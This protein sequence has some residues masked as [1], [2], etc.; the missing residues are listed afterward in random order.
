LVLSIIFS[1]VPKKVALDYISLGAYGYLTAGW[2][3]TIWM[4][5][6]LAYMF[7]VYKRFNR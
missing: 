1:V 2:M 4:A 5:L 7:F 6:P 3:P